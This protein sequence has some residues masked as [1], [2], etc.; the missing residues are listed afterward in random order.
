MYMKEK[1][2]TLTADFTVC[3]ELNVVLKHIKLALGHL[4]NTRVNLH[5]SQKLMKLQN[6]P[7]QVLQCRQ[8]MN[9]GQQEVSHFELKL[10]LYSAFLRV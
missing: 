2:K 9:R 1:K 7:Q 3:L 8:V 10:L 4:K 6:L 5:H